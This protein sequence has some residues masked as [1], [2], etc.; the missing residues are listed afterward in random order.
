VKK[1]FTRLAAVSA[2]GFVA[3]TGVLASSAT[4]GAPAPN[5]GSDAH[6]RPSVGQ[7]LA[8]VAKHRPGAV[9]TSANAAPEDIVEIATAVSGD[10]SC[11]D[12]VNGS[13]AN[14]ADVQQYQCVGVPQQR[15]KIIPATDP[16]WF[17]LQFQHNTTKCLDVRG[18]GL[19]NGTQY[20]QW[21]CVADAKAQQFTAYVQSSPAP[22]VT[23]VP[24]TTFEA[25]ELHAKCTDVRGGS[26]ANGAKIQQWACATTSDANN[27]VVTAQVVSIY[28]VG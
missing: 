14:G 15:F 16:G 17:S 3:L 2:I 23:L 28:K 22:T 4:A 19:S 12:V 26:S 18:A 25:N 9:T 8:K 13:Q 20:Q 10:A 11:F 24:R 27:D 21:D 5:A 7:M 6:Q 1:Q